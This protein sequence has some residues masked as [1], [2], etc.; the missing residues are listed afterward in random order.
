MNRNF[1]QNR[2]E[3]FQLKP[4]RCVL[5]VFGS[6]VPAGTGLATGLMLGAFQNYLY[7]VAFL[8]HNNSDE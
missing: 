7:S 5:F 8:C 4:F 2:V 6:D 3:F 1:F